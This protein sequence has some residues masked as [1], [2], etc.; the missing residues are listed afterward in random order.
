MDSFSD[1]EVVMM[2]EGG[3]RQLEDFLERQGVGVGT[4]AEGGDGMR[5][6]RTKAAR[7]YRESL[8]KH[9]EEERRL[10]RRT[11]GAKDCRSEA[12]ANAL[13]RLPT[14]L[15]T[16]RLSLRS[17]PFLIA[18]LG[19]VEK[20]LEGWEGRARKEGGGGKQ[21]EKEGERKKEKKDKKKKK[22][23]KERRPKSPSP[24][25]STP[26]PSSNPT[27]VPTPQK[28][29]MKRYTVTYHEGP[30]G[31]SLCDNL[32]VNGMIEV[33]R[34]SPYTQSEELGVMAGDKVLE[35]EGEGIGGF[36]DTKRWLKKRPVKVTFG[37]VERRRE[38]EL[39]SSSMA[40][41]SA[42]KVENG[43]GRTL[44]GYQPR[45]NKKGEVRL[46]DEGHQRA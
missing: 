10:E 33:T 44:E 32:Q 28:P 40:T 31:V 8:K 12:T 18:V 26:S 6:Y 25:L 15:T 27:V 42:K 35:I 39:R 20:G 17:S 9:G 29:S 41:G 23:R 19:V 1:Q 5:V 16:F 43:G 11:V 7:Y 34:V 38:E 13:H 45:F 3:N 14:R 24:S 22:D 30:L 4:K 2:L 36:E 46:S 21:E 37:R